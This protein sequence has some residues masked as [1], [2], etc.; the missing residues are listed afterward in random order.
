MT[1]KTKDKKLEKKLA[2]LEK[3][4]EQLMLK[5]EALQQSES[6]AT[7]EQSLMQ[8]LFDDIPAYIYFKDK[9]RRF[10]RASK[11][12]CKLFNCGLEGIIGKKDEDLFPKEIA[13]ETAADDRRVIETGL[14]LINK[15]EGGESI[16]DGGHWVLTT[17]IPW[18]DTKGHIIGLFGISKDITD[19]KRAEKSL[20]ESE[21][22]F[23]NLAEQSPNMIFINSRG[24]VVY[25]NQKCVE[26]TGYGLGEFYTDDFD[27][28]KLI[29]PEY[30]DLIKRNFGK[31]MAGEE[32]NPYE[33]A[34]VSKSGE[35][36]EVII[37][38]KLI[39]YEGESAI[40]GIVTDITERKLAEKN[41][42]EKDKEL[43]Q[44]AKNLEEMN[45]ALKILLE[46]RDK[47]KADMKENLL[48]SLKRLVFPYI[49]K[50][51]KNKIGE[52]S[53]TYINIIKSNLEDVIAPI[54]DTLSSKYLGLTPS[55][56]QVA[57]L[58][59]QGLTSK[60]IAQILNVSHKAV[61]FHR[62]NIRKK[63]GLWNKKMNL[64]TY[65]QSFPDRQSS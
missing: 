62:G 54:S 50:L 64:T 19:L 51:Q 52:E 46:Q 7:Y 58:I 30:L 44:Q 21:G 15:E 20:R 53:L 40:L 43:K 23:K 45:V 29:A 27:F 9:N 35:R 14:S 10:V 17:K 57:N 16:G 18:R 33:Y 63:L 60:E 11:Y 22:K 24:R 37:T 34:L 1:H 25:A 26:I 36:I 3:A 32:V 4:N 12:F 31:H 59:K 48:M 65:L 38:T 42:H 61:S 8:A 39:H 47:E 6:Q 49:E 2:D 55:E 56:I 5:I 41:L 13:K 28:L